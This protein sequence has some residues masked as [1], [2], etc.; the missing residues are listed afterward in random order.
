MNMRSR[1][2]RLIQ[3]VRQAS[4]GVGALAVC[5]ALLACHAGAVRGDNGPQP[6]EFAASRRFA[7][8]SFT[9]ADAATP[10]S[11]RYGGKENAWASWD[12]TSSRREVDEARDEQKIVWRDQATG[13]EVRCVAITYKDFPVVEWTVSLEHTGTANTPL[14]ENLLGLDAFFK[15]AAPGPC[16]VHGIKGDFCTADSYEPFRLE[17]ASGAT[18]E[19]APPGSG[20]SSDGADG[21]PYHNLQ[22]GGGGSIIAIGWPGQ[23][24]SRFTCQDDGVRAQAGQ[25]L[26][27]F[28]LR[29]GEKVRTPLIAV[30]FWQGDDVVRS[31]NLWRRWYRSH[32]LPKTNGMPQGPIKQIQVGGGSTEEVEQFVVAEIKPDVCW[33]DA[34]GSNTWYPSTEGP[35]GP[36]GTTTNPEFTAMGWLNTGTWEIDREKYPQGFRPFSDWCRAHGMQFLLWFEPERVG[37]PMSWLATMRREWLLPGTNTTVGDIFDL[38]NPA[39]RTWLI[40]HLDRMIKTEGIDWYREDMNGGGPLPA[41]RNHD[42]PDRQGITE[43]LY[44]QGHLQ[45]WDELR[46]RNPGLRIDSCASGGRRNDLETMRRAV[47]LLRSDFQFPDTQPGVVEGN[48]CHTHALSSWLPFQGSGCYV[49]DPYAFR[50]FYLPSFGMGGLSAGNTPFQQQA[51]REC[52]QIAPAMLSGDYY[53]LTPYSLA[54]DTWIAWQFDRPDTG[55]GCVQAFRRPD[56]ASPTLTVRLRGL[57]ESRSYRVDD[58]DRPVDRT[59][60]IAKPS[61]DARTG[62]QLMTEGI[63]IELERRGS[64]VLRY[65]AILSEE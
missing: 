12:R 39:A 62:H 57:D 11:F 49:Y 22:F 23:W 51:Y 28:S 8:S 61:E 6:E 20:K 40:D 53:P 29:P 13:L 4:Q 17:L 46:R 41:W 32:V 19:F 18:K 3:H 30:L 64:A 33:R 24:T 27:R 37:S 55:D 59:G 44:V 63:T 52:G 35:Y 58:F 26:T 65:V 42:G 5:A 34:G 38:G 31:Q 10:F 16:A 2:R 15:A 45:L 48:Q 25:Q 21:W 56:A 7:S 60:S 54:A 9:A 47:P 1:S 14:I 43:N 36:G 50:S